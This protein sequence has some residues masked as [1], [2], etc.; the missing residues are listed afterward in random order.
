MTFSQ[1]TSASR[2]MAFTKYVYRY[3]TN[4]KQKCLALHL[5]NLTFSLSKQ[6]R[7]LRA[8]LL[9]SFNGSLTHQEKKMTVQIRHKPNLYLFISAQLQFGPCRH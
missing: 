7:R 1:L 8:R 3:V 6:A 5:L 4:A 9:P 2:F